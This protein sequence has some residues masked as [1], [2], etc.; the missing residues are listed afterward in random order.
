MDTKQIVKLFVGEIEVNNKQLKH[1]E[2]AI[3]IQHFRD[4]MEHIIL[5]DGIDEAIKQCEQIIKET[6][7]NNP[8]KGNIYYSAVR[9]DN[10]RDI[11]FVRHAHGGGNNQSLRVTGG[12]VVA[13]IKTIEIKGELSPIH[14]YTWYDI[15]KHNPFA[16]L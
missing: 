5:I 1:G 12:V 8:V 3:I 6:T 16:F 7:E 13:T 2:E 4:D 10:N 15:N 14:G 11:E 9:A